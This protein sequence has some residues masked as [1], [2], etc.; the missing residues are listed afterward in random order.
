MADPSNPAALALRAPRSQ[1]AAPVVPASFARLRSTTAPAGIPRLLVGWS[2]WRQHAPWALPLGPLAELAFIPRL[3]LDGFVIAPASW[4]LPDDLQIGTPDGSRALRDGR[5]EKP[6]SAHAKRSQQAI[7][8]WRR[9]AGVPRYVQVGQGDELLPVDL[10]A[11]GAAADL[12]GH[13]RV[14]EIWPPVD[15]SALCDRDGRR[16]EAVVMLIE[17]PDADA[18][19]SHLRWSAAVRAA[20]A[21]PPPHRAPASTD[22]TTYKL[23]GPAARQDDL[24]TSLVPIVR[25]GQ[26]ADEIDRWFF[27]RYVDGPGHRHHLRL[28]VHARA[29]GAA[30][31]R[32]LRTRL[33][34]ARATAVLTGITVDEYHPEH[35]R[36]RADELDAV[37]TLFESD[38]ELAVGLLHAAPWQA[39]AA[40]A[41]SANAPHAI[42]PVVLFV[43]ACD[44][45]A[46][47]LGLDLDARH[48]LAK[49]RRHAAE[50]SADLADDDR[51][52][53][54]AGFRAAGRGLRA[55]LIADSVGDS[56]GD[57][58]P[59]AAPLAAHRARVAH[60][61]HDL[62][63]DA[64]A[65]LLPTLLHLS[66][67]RCLGPH[68]D[69]ERLAYTFWERTL[70]GMRRPA[71]GGG[72]GS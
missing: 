61:A 19:A 21:V 13:R 31:A 1:G 24:L 4:R 33:Q 34:D 72:R 70:S 3:C 39:A 9:V 38:S 17:Q 59:H 10:A 54:D 58:D 62:S 68:P 28:R 49:Q 69:R 50:A 12:G 29:D 60:A 44:A 35:G 40:P 30:F 5:P 22:W 14:F 57:T 65:R 46:S 32:R 45:L 11:A 63:R 55:A 15:E 8:R 20:G 47:G 51:A 27:Q 37:F 7:R 43:R 48:A 64:R 52:Y 25:A 23:F 42:D 16:L 6:V 36:F 66:A 2:L 71:G 56:G 67:V 18:T 41:M 53:A 26:H